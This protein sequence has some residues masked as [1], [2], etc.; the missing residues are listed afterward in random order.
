MHTPWTCHPGPCPSR[1][2]IE[3]P[4]HLHPS[5]AGP[6]CSSG[7]HWGQW[8]ARQ[9]LPSVFPSSATQIQSWWKTL[10]H[11]VPSMSPKE[12]QGGRNSEPQKAHPWRMRR[13][14]TTWWGPLS[15]HPDSL[16]QV[17]TPNVPGWPDCV[18]RFLYLHRVS[19]ET[20]LHHPSQ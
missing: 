13:G 18:Y 6:E 19:T 4:E 14:G 2:L 10:L 16:V 11:S 9:E 1:L 3:Q 15:L 20:A 12:V 5:S 8:A 7:W 17:L